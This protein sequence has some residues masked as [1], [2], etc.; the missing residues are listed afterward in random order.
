M[1]A[2]AGPDAAAAPSSGD[3]RI[4]RARGLVLDEPIPDLATIIADWKAEREPSRVPAAPARNAN[5]K[6]GRS[7]AA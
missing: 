5:E 7:R 6:P 4:L 1:L 3:R 2:L